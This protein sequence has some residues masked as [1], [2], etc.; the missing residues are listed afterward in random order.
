MAIGS[1]FLV[2]LDHYTTSLLVPRGH[3]NVVLVS[4]PAF[5]GSSGEVKVLDNQSCAFLELE[6][7]VVCGFGCEHV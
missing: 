5:C 7:V 4:V 2:K 3:L 1:T 6:E